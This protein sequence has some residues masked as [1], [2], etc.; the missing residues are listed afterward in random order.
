MEIVIRRA[1]NNDAGE[2]SQMIR[3]NASKMLAPYYTR[4]QWDI[5]NTYYSIEAMRTKIKE[6]I[7]FCAEL[8]NQI[9]AS[10]GIDKDTVV[11]FY[12]RL[13]YLNQGIGTKILK[14]AETLPWKAACKK[15][16]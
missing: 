2:L 14:H 4:Q 15:S 6:Q 7:I 1:S 3:D 9:V 12:T 10:V 13:G 8:N 16:S 11:G 5:F